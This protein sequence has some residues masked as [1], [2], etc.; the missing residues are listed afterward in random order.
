MTFKVYLKYYFIF[1]HEN[2]K[3]ESRQKK[4]EF[5]SLKID[6]FCYLIDKT[7]YGLQKFMLPFDVN[8]LIFQIS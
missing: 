5:H 8:N 6:F 1:S 4:K 2:I 3:C 7:G